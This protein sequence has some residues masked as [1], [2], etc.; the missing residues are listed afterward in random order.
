MGSITL[1]RGGVVLRN[2]TFNNALLC[3]G[4]AD[5]SHEATQQCR[6]GGGRK[7]EEPR[8]KAA[9][10]AGT[11]RGEQRGCS[12]AGAAIPPPHPSSAVRPRP[13]HAAFLMPKTPKFGK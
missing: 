7:G 10:P 2:E 1:L 3:S 11:A 9:L 5:G 6:A 8:L 4:G 12:G 13:R